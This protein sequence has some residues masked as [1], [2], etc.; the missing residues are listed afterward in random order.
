M[1]LKR[2][3]IFICILF[4]TAAGRGQMME[5][6]VQE[7]E[8]GVAVGAGHYFGDLNTRAAL[9][10]P[11]F[12]AGAFFR[13]Q[14]GNY[15]GVKLAANYARLGYSDV[16]SENEI[17]KRRNLSFNSNIWEVSLSGDFNFFKF[18]P[19]IS[20]FTY[21]PYV[22]LG[23]GVFSYDPYAYLGDQKYFL[24]AIGTEG[25]GS[26]L[27]PERKAYGSMGVCF[28]VAVG[29]KYNVSPSVNMFA[30]VGY[31][32]TNADYLDD[33]SMTYAP[34]AFSPLPNGSPSIGQL[35]SDRSYET[36]V[37]IGIKNR[38]RGNSQQKDA[39]VLAQIGVSFNISSY[40]CPKF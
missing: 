23:V 29:F 40:R 11:K 8:F 19:G 32:F 16:Y 25:Q 33:V 36:G 35:L 17:Q 6:Y 12:S 13:K 22:S 1:I 5:S 21:T 4:V 37:P 27:Y 10:R 9:N 26:A 3:T 24:R 30:E 34:D 28:P 7:G 15:I 31:R 18:Y 2:L 38:Q 20:G 14:F 39:Y